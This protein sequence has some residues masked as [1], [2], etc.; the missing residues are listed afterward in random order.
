MHQSE[1]LRRITA[2]SRIRIKI[3][4]KLE[5]R[6]E[7]LGLECLSVSKAK[8]GSDAQRVSNELNS[9]FAIPERLML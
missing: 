9:A 8:G 1:A 6:A 3:W 4:E 5:A 7:S 2:R